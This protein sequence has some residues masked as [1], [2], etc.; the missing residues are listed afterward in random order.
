MDNEKV[1]ENETLL[2]YSSIKFC[3]KREMH[4][5]IIIGSDINN[6]RVVEKAIDEISSDLGISQDNYGKIMVSAMEAVNN[7]IIHGN[8]SVSSRKVTIEIV[9]KK[10]ILT[11]SVEDE[12]PGFKPMEIPDP[13]RPENIEHISGRGVFLMSRLADEIEFNERGNKV[14]MSFKDLKT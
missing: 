5:N 13:T 2:K 14:T 11:I 12:G 7:A 4:R 1:K 9:H 3:M 6:L 10:K 8:K